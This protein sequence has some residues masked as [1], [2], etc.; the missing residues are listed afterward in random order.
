L[1]LGG[2]N[3]YEIVFTNGG[4]DDAANVVLT[5][6]LPQHTSF[7]SASVSQGAVSFDGTTVTANLGGIA[8][9]DSATLTLVV[10]VNTDTPHGA[11]IHNTATATSDT[12]DPFTD[13]NSAFA[14]TVVVGPYSGDVIISEFRFRGPGSSSETAARAHVESVQSGSTDEF[15]EL[16]N[17]TDL[18]IT[19]ADS[20]GGGGWALVSSDD[21]ANPKC[22]IP[23]GSVIAARGHF[24]C[25]NSSGYS[26]NGYPAGATTT[27]TGDATYVADIP[28]D[29]GIALFTTTD[30][31]GFDAGH[32]L[33]AVGFAAAALPPTIAPAPSN[34]LYREGGGLSQQ[35]VTQNA[36]FSFVRRMET[37][38]PQDTDD[39]AADFVLVA[40]DPDTLGDGSQLGAPGPENTSSPV[41]RDDIKSVLIEPTASRN[42]PPNRVRDA[43]PVKNGS[44]GTLSIRRRFVN[45]T[46]ATVTRLRFLVVNITTH[47][48]PVAVAPQADMRLLDSSDFNITTSLGDLTVQG[49]TVEQPP[50]QPLG[51]GLNSTAT[52]T[53]PQGGLPSGASVDVQFLLGIEQTGNFRF[54]VIIQGLADQ[55]DVE[56]KTPPAASKRLNIEG[57]KSS[58]GKIKN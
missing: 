23:N 40:T 14:D 55:T 56:L 18:D 52:V 11:T 13:N 51:G 16:Y 53:L 12:P 37:G 6:P 39:N 1:Q 8:A 49:T 17:N 26:L 54:F 19:V 31:G 29:A 50:T 34:T 43:T 9:F 42:D 21:T 44:H 20:S 7:V 28:D 25:V 10:S 48:S 57:V 22:V 38:R 2:Q 58:G 35:P 27:A 4:P 45:D 41:G 5:D 3:N 33:D 36:E 24:L 47:D 46:G 30:P 15:I 32:R